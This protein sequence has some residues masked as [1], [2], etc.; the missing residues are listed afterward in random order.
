VI[1]G[2]I[3]GK[4]GQNVLSIIKQS[5]SKDSIEYL[6]KVSKDKKIELMQKSQLIAVTSVKEGWGLIITEANS[7]GTPAIVYNVDG[8]RDAVKAGQT[9]LV[10][11]ENYPKNLAKNIIELLA[12]EEKY[13]H[14]RLNAWQWSKEINFNNSYRDF[15]NA[16]VEFK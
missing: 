10:C 12:N 15:I 8:L 14:Y 2:A 16:L 7:Q 5:K 6:G 9:G 1:A 11:Q 3:E 4:Y 13:Q